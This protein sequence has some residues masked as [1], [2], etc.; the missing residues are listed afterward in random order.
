[1]IQEF[2]ENVI[3]LR[4]EIPVAIRNDF[5]TAG[6]KSVKIKEDT[7]Y[8]TDG[9]EGIYMVTKVENGKNGITVTFKG[10]GTYS[11]DISSFYTDDMVNVYEAVHGALGLN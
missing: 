7:V 9:G 5:K 8:V 1:M 10:D 6:K 3:A 2:M 11:N 4:N